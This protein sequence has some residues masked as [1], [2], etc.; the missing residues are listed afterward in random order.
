MSPS[1]EGSLKPPPTMGNQGDKGLIKPGKGLIT[2]QPYAKALDR[3]PSASE[4]GSG[5]NG[6]VSQMDSWP[7]S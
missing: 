1:P 6:V 3:S 2:S 7:T 5:L 4:I